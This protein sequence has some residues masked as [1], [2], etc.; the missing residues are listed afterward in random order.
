MPA[1]VL[2]AAGPL[3]QRKL[4][5]ENYNTAWPLQTFEAVTYTVVAMS[6]IFGFVIA[7]GAAALVT[8]FFPESVAALRAA[9]RRMFGVDA[10]MALAGAAGLTLVLRQAAN[11]MQARFHAEAIYSLGN[12]DLLITTAPALAAIATAVRS[13]LI[14]AALL[15]ILVLV[16]RRLPQIWLRWLLGLLVAFAILPSDVRTPGEFALAYGIAI[17]ATG[18]AAAFCFVFARGNYLAYALVFWALALRSPLAEL[19][20]I[21]LAPLQVQA[22][23]VAGALAAGVA[24]ALLPAITLKANP[25]SAANSA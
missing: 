25:S 4:M 12:S 2:A 3:L 5:M 16:A 14:D 17:A 23:I 11:A 20:G 18:C 21:P 1:T 6:V 13:L 7:T 24:W 19:F 8:S 22:W 10:V 9:G 15:A